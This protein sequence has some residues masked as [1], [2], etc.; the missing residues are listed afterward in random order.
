MPIFEREGIALYYEVEGRRGVP[1]V[2]IQGVGVI[3][4]GWRPQVD[5]LASEFKTLVFDNRGIGKSTPYDGPVLVESMAEDVFALINHL[6]WES[7]HVVGHSLGGVIAQ[8]FAL[9]HPQQV[10]SL[11]LLCTFSQGAQ[12]ARLS[13]LIVWLG[14]RT[15]IGTRQSRRRAFLEILLPRKEVQEVEDITGLAEQYAQWIGRDLADQPPI[16]MKQLRALAKHDASK[17]LHRLGSIPTLVLSAD[18]DPIALP[19]FGKDL[20]K[21]IPGAQFEL[22]RGVSHGVSLQEPREINQRIKNFILECEKRYSNPVKSAKV[23]KRKRG[24]A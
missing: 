10:R 17:E 7:A 12:G 9:N 13:P 6:G 3:G 20:A 8:Q 2:F 24:G 23:A 14:L 5:E 11:S 22:L 19:E 18:E 21:R 1:I 16:V 15:R 4:E